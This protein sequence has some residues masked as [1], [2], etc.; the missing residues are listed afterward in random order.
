MP[1]ILTIVEGG[2][3]FGCEGPPA[4]LPFLSE[5]LAAFMPKLP[6]AEAQRLAG[7]WAGTQMGSRWARRSR[8]P[9]IR[10]KAVLL[11]FPVR[12]VCRT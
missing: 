12:L 3:V 9:S 8:V 10:Q 7:R 11:A 1:A 5:G 4:R 2:L 6:T